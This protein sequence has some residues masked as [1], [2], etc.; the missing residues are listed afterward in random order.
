MIWKGAVFQKEAQLVNQTGKWHD[1]GHHHQTCC[2][3][4][5]APQ[6]PPQL[7]YAS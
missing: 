5:I 1:H 4:L 6:T 2:Y 3:H 7:K